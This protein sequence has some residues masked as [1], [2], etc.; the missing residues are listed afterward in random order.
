MT[1]PIDRCPLCSRGGGSHPTAPRCPGSQALT[2]L[3]SASAPPTTAPDGL[4][5]VLT[6]TRSAVVSGGG[7]GLTPAL[8]G[9]KSAIKRF[10]VTLNATLGTSHGTSQFLIARTYKI[11]IFSIF[12]AG[13][14]RSRELSSAPRRS[15]GR[16][17]TSVC[18][19]GSC[20]FR[21]AGHSWAC[22]PAAPRGSARFALPQ[23]PIWP[24]HSP[25]G[26]EHTLN[27]SNMIGALQHLLLAIPSPRTGPWALRPPKPRGPLHPLADPRASLLSFLMVFLLLCP[28]HR[29]APPWN[30]TGPEEGCLTAPLWT[31]GTGHWGLPLRATA[32]QLFSLQVP[33]PWRPCPQQLRQGSF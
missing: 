4:G 26:L 14:L 9:Q 12:R 6:N 11:G 32:T 30:D 3:F 20:C 27:P 19:H 21:H 8:Q 15:G 5:P 18:C 22:H 25:L 10:Y 17:A 1:A 28:I 29:I 7:Y 2:C 13:T 16:G 33:S 24:S 31:A 23:F